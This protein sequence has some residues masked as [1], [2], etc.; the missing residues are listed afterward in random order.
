MMKRL[1][2]GICVLALLFTGCQNR[3]NTDEGD[4]AVGQKMVKKSTPKKKKRTLSLQPQASGTPYEMLV[5]MGEE[6]WE[7]PVGRA[8][9]SVLDTDLPGVAQPERQFRI[10]RIDPSSYGNMYKVPSLLIT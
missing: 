10:S 6:Q 8:L 9:F 3:T 4:S 2:I 7:R 1:T 5:I